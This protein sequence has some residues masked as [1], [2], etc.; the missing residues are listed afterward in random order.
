MCLYRILFQLNSAE[1]R[2]KLRTQFLAPLLPERTEFLSKQIPYLISFQAESRSIL[3]LNSGQ[4][5]VR[6]EHRMNHIDAQWRVV[7][8]H[9]YARVD[10]RGSLLGDPLHPPHTRGRLLSVLIT[11]PIKYTKANLL[12]I[13]SVLIVHTK[14]TRK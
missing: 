8:L 5:T 14:S 3:Q 10:P 2:S 12:K 7:A 13:L 1:S 11:R 9:F 4:V 6:T